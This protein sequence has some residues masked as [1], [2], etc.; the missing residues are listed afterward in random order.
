MLFRKIKNAQY[1]FHPDYWDPVGTEAKDL[2]AKLLK[3]NPLERLTV[4]E[5]LNHDWLQLD[6]GTLT[7][8]KLEGAMDELRRFNAKRKFRFLVF[9]IF[10]F[11]LSSIN[12]KT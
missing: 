6:D 9:D 11:H 10:R 2:I 7:N 8:R 4:D 1:Q 3:P 5:A 12:D